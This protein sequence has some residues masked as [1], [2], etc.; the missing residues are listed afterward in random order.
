MYKVILEKLKTLIDLIAMIDKKLGFY[1]FI[2][3]FIFIAIIV[4][5]FNF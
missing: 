4:G 5:I 2:Q 1:K 3:Y